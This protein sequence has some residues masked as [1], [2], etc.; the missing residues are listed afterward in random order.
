M[1][2]EPNQRLWGL[3]IG[4]VVFYLVAGY[5]SC[6]ELGYA[7][8]G[9]TADAT[10]V[11]VASDSGC[12]VAGRGRQGRLIEYRFVN[13]DG[14]SRGGQIHQGADAPHALALGERVPVQYV[15]SMDQSRVLGESYGIQV[16]IFIPL[17]VA[18]F[19]ALYLAWVLRLPHTR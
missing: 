7:L 2:T 4:L 13:S 14:S 1:E 8:W 3:V 10:V 11:G 19:C 6:L 17:T 16:L 9:Q 12:R 5:F 15:A 18:G